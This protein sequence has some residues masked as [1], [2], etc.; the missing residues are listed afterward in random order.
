MWSWLLSHLA[1]TSGVVLMVLAIAKILSERRTPQSIAAWLLVIVLLPWVGVPLFLAFG[2]R[3]MRELADSKRDVE[4]RRV[5]SRTGSDSPVEQTLRSLGLPPATEGNRVKFAFDG[6]AAYEAL[7]SMIDS[8]QESIEYATFILA[9]DDVGK[10]VVRKLTEKANAGCRV[11]LLLDGLG[12]RKANRQF[13]EDFL[14][15]GGQVAWFMPAMHR[16]FRGRTNLRN[17][18]KIVV[19]DGGRAWA[20]GRNTA[21]EYFGPHPVAGRWDDL[22]VV[23]EGPAVGGFADIFES[24]WAFATK[25]APATKAVSSS[26]PVGVDAVQVVPSGPDVPHDALLGGLLTATFQ[27]KRAIRIVTPYLVPP[28]AI[29]QALCLA[30]WRGVDVQL[31]MPAVS[32]HRLADWARGPHLAELCEAGAKIL[33]LPRMIHAKGAIFDDEL[34]FVGS[35]NLDERSLLLN[36]EVMAALYGG[37]QLQS[38]TEWFDS[39]AAECRPWEPTVGRVRRMAEGL[40]ELTAP[41]L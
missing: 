3:K 14:R 16:P 30:A 5:P 2:G 27:A 10:A 40:A 21:E 17:H 26:S 22:T 4:L 39:L 11:R 8:A 37:S 35:A 23:I 34:A 28:D 9:T 36:F 20:G 32:N 41:L 18:R 29:T 38:L 1:A 13:L 31:L 12:S 6:V 15:A 33:L 7:I 25:T 19:V 24:D